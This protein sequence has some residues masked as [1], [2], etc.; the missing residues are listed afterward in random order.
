MKALKDELL[1]LIWY[2]R[3]GLSYTEAHLLSPDERE[4]IGKIIEGNL[5][6]TQK[7]QLPFF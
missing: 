5:E 4:I 1:R 6:T 7:T 3:G 2:M